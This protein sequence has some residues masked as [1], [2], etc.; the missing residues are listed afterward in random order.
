MVSARS[1]RVMFASAGPIGA[2]GVW[3]VG[4]DQF[5][6]PREVAGI[7]GGAGIGVGDHG[8]IFPY[9]AARRPRTDDPA[10]SGRPSLSQERPRLRSMR[11]TLPW[12]HTGQRPETRQHE[13]GPVP[14]PW[15]MAQRLRVREQQPGPDP[16]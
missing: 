12:S 6:E 10:E 8:P 4:A 9:Q 15:H 2:A 14:D 13:R 11:G 16:H 3:Q 1:S 5:A 7:R